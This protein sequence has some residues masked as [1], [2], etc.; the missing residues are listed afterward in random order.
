MNSPSSQISVAE[1]PSPRAATRISR[2][3]LGQTF[4]RTLAAWPLVALLAG[5]VAR[6]LLQSDLATIIWAIGVVPV[7]IALVAQMVDSLRHREVGLDTVALLSMS[8]ALLLGET[9]AGNVVALMYAGGQLLESYADG[10]ARREMSALLART[11]KSSVRYGAGGLEE[12][13]VE[14]IVPGDRI[15]VRTGDTLPVDG[16]VVGP[17]ALLDQSALTGESLPVRHAIGAPVA[18]GSVNVGD[19][20][21][22][23]AKHNAEESTYAGI[24]RLVEAAEK[25]KAPMVRLA[26]RYALWFL[27]VTIVVSGGAWLATGDPVRALAVLV[28][29]TPCPLILAVPVAIISG[30]SLAARHGLLVKGGGVLEALAGIRT[31]VIDKTGTLTAGRA[32]LIA[33]HPV[34]GFTA[35]EV[36]GL[37]ASLD[38]ASNHTIADALVAAARQ[39]GV[40]LRPPADVKETTGS[41]LEGTVDARRVVIGGIGFVRSRADIENNFVP[42]VSKGEGV[43]GVAVAVDG[44]AAGTLHFAD[45]VRPEVPAV[46]AALRARGVDRI[47]LASGDRD[48]VTRA[49]A[50]R[51]KVDEVKSELTPEQKVEVVLAERQRGPVMMVGDGVNDSPALAAADIGV[52]MGARGAAPSSEAADAVLLVDRLD[53][54]VEGIDVARRSRHIALQSVYAGVG[55]SLVAMGFAAFGY[56][57]PVAGALLQEAIDV[58]VIL[59][60]LRALRDPRRP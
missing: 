30:V 56:L 1:A 41:G 14:V 24:V 26:D 45:E 29:A 58:A 16:T 36:L 27:L 18:S 22:L 46:L 20:F 6:F 39:R 9:L 15:L 3:W 48:D 13:P 47:V 60:A 50:A 53:R 23:A 57:Q 40:A 32:S 7:L 10:R 59:N 33:V 37:A 12:V 31:V 54:L 4:A 34:N 2:D 35:D 49:V 52:A 8:G 21:D 51:L 25:A 5:L 43:L 28:V 44:T 55:L 17:T 19:A 38:Q 42:A 11:P